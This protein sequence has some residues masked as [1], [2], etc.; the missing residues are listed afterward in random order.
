MASDRPL[1]AGV[2]VSVAGDG[3][4]RGDHPA[5]GD[6]PSRRGGAAGVAVAGRR[7]PDAVTVREVAWHHLAAVA[8]RESL[9][10]EMLVRYSGRPAGLAAETPAQSAGAVAY[11]GV[12]FTPEGLPVGHAALRWNDDDVELQRVYVTPPYRGSGTAAALLAAAEDAARTLRVRRIIL[13]P[14]DQ[15]PGDARFWER[16][17]YTCVAVIPPFPSALAPYC[18]EKVIGGTLPHAD[19]RRDGPSAPLPTTVI[20]T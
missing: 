1:R 15:E 16:A 14:G 3:T 12:A 11:T 10:A 19:V 6:R 7:L 5:P 17:G 2:P 4:R 9:A 18:L 20:S 13:R 8:L